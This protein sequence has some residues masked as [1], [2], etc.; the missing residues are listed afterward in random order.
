LLGRL[1]AAGLYD[2]SLL[3]LASD[4]GVSF[5]PGAQRRWATAANLEDIAPVPLFI[6]RPYQRLGRIDDRYLRTVDILPTIA[7][8]L[9]VR[10]PW[11]TDGQSAF[12]PPAP[13]RRG[14]ELWDRSGDRFALD[15][16]TFERRRRAALERQIALFGVGSAPPG[17][18]GIGPHPELLGRSADGLRSTD[19]RGARAE[20]DGVESLRSVDPRSDFIPCRIKG[21]IHGEGGVARDIAIAVNGRVVAAARSSR[22][23]GDETFSVL[24]P[25]SSFRAGA[26]EV[27][28]FAVSTRGGTLRLESL[29]RA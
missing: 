28:V 7:D 25:E 23:A 29:A 12:G 9:G 22:E 10:I 4:H 2:R 16:A 8:V 3:V 24:V 13:R 17:L 27:E 1:R 6:K 11:A 21:R 19:V 14:V 5:H 18:Y 26:N 20:I 15:A